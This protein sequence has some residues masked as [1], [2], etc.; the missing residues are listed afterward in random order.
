MRVLAIDTLMQGCCVGCYDSEAGQSFSIMKEI[1]R[2]HA[3]VLV[4]MIDDLLRK[5]RWRYADIDLI[6]V[7]TGPGAFTS[8]RIGL[9]TVKALSLSLD[10]PAIGV[11]SFDLIYALYGKEYNGNICI[12]LETKRGDYYMALYSSNGEVIKAG[13]CDETQLLSDLEEHNTS[14]VIGDAV[15]RFQEECGYNCEFL[16]LKTRGSTFLLI[17]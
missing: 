9:S 7:T 12:L 17:R 13:V 16:I 5:V 14:C 4:P 11:S 2:G 8:L 6:G 10:K 1:E 15:E 3:E